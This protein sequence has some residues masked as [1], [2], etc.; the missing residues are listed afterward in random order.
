MFEHTET[1]GHAS[2]SAK[3]L[4][5]GGSVGVKQGSLSGQGILSILAEE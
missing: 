3:D 5:W 2:S 1:S 4:S